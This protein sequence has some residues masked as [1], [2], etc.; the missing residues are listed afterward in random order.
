MKAK[1]D[2]KKRKSI[3]IGLITTII[4]IIAISGSVAFIKGNRNASAKMN[5]NNITENTITSS[6]E[7][8]GNQD[9][10]INNNVESAIS[11]ENTNNNTENQSGAT[12]IENSSNT[13]NL[14][15]NN[16]SRQQNNTQSTT[17]SS[18]TNDSNSPS[19]EY[20]QTTIIPNGGEERLVSE[21][22]KIGWRP[23]TVSAKTAVAEI[24]LVELNIESHK[25]SYINNDST[26]DEPIH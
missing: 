6:T 8:N 12:E 26:N 17:N 20:T 13:T 21:E 9:D 22:E 16:G 14:V 19:R 5:E 4:A 25:L 10:T 23:I 18:R 7:N 3:I 24:D 2:Y 15:Q 1:L 11:N